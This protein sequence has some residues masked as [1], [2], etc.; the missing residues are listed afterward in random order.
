VAHE[1]EAATGGKKKPAL[2]AWYLQRG[3]RPPTTLDRII[4]HPIG[5]EAVLAAS[6]RRHLERGQ[7]FKT[8]STPLVP[9]ADSGQSFGL[10]L[11]PEPMAEMCKTA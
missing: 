11:G 5:G 8:I 7:L 4:G 2:M 3:W 9:I 1:I 10:A 6:Q